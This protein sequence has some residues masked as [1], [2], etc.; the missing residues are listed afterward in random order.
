MDPAAA[1][2]ANDWVAVLAASAI[3]FVIGGLWYGAQL[4]KAWMGVTGITEDIMAERNQVM[5]FGMAFVLNV[6]MVVKL[7]M[8]I[9]PAADIVYGAAAGFFTGTFWAYAMLDI[10]NSSE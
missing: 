8:F 1:F 6:I 2:L 4:G 3:A 7:A 5:I 10:L 9:R